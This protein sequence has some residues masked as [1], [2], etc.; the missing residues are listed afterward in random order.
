MSDQPLSTSLTLLNRLRAPKDP[1]D[2]KTA[3]GQFF[4]LYDPLLLVWVRR[5]AGQPADSDDLLQSFRVKIMEALPR[6]A[7]TEKGQFRGW[8]WRVL[9]NA[10]RDLRRRNRPAHPLDEQNG[11][12]R[13]SDEPEWDEAEYRQYV[14]RRALEIL[15][16][17]FSAQQAAILTQ[18][19]MNG[20]P[21]A[22]VAAELGVAEGTVYS[23]C[24]R[25]LRQLR[26]TI[27]GLA[28]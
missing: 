17:D 21:A 23:T 19:V 14:V 9:D 1:T 27:A 25:V 3:W 2:R 5:H 13:P 6:Y 20:R 16:R 28:E 4:A 12:A 24:S 26:E 11:P 18:H 8:L 7:R 10:A 15:S 22:D